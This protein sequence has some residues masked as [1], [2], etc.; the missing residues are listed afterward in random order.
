[1]P[2]E[3]ATVARFLAS[4]DAKWVSGEAVLVARGHRGLRDEEQVR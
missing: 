3:I 1:M 4:D 2:V